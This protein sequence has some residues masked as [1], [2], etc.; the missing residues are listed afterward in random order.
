MTLIFHLFPSH[1]NVKNNAKV[2]KICCDSRTVRQGCSRPWM[3]SHERSWKI[4]QL[5]L[6]NLLFSKMVIFLGSANT[7]EQK[8]IVS[9]TGRCRK[10]DESYDI[11]CK[12]ISSDALVWVHPGL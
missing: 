10:F 5:T 9:R 7:T 1:D 2:G 4:N 8:V 12:G 11:N 3:S 6:M